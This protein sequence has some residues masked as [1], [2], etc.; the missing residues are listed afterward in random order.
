MTPTP[1]RTNKP[2]PSPSKTNKP[3]PTPTR[4]NKPTPTPTRTNKPTPTPTRTN[5]PTPSPSKTNKPTP[6]PTRTPTPTMFS[7]YQSLWKGVSFN[8]LAGA[9]D[10]QDWWILPNSITPEPPFKYSQENQTLYI[11]KDVKPAL[12]G[13]LCD[14]YGIGHP[15]GRTALSGGHLRF[16]GFENLKYISLGQCPVSAVELGNLPNFYEN[17]D[18]N[19]GTFICYDNSVI[20]NITTNSSF[21]CSK[22]H[23][24]ECANV[25]S[26]VELPNFSTVDKI[27]YASFTGTSVAFQE[28]SE[29]FK[30][31]SN[32]DLQLGAVFDTV[33]DLTPFTDL[34]SLKFYYDIK[35]IY[36][37]QWIDVEPW[38]G[39]LVTKRRPN[40]I[41]PKTERFLVSKQANS[42]LRRLEF[43][44]FFEYFDVVIDGEAGTTPFKGLSSVN[45]EVLGDVS[46]LNLIGAGLQ[47][48]DFSEETGFSSCLSG[49][50]YCSISKT[51]VPLP[52]LAFFDYNSNFNGILTLNTGVLNLDDR[53]N[54]TQQQQQ[55]LVESLTD[56]KTINTF[57]KKRVIGLE[58]SF[59]LML[60]NKGW[61]TEWIKWD[62]SSDYS[63]PTSLPPFNTTQFNASLYK[64]TTT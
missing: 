41:T 24:F 53:T 49:V 39:K 4:T 60:R 56:R 5:K 59:D 46:V 28:I 45:G 12:R 19:S 8:P 38:P 17:P 15:A 6:T 26:L 1:T 16:D 33:L 43:F 20:K 48:A 10:L 63:L 7:N 40:V 44:G 50:Q 30:K 2:T 34:V 37:N 64:N 47:L 55:T 42:N 11:H 51:I 21:S 3:T 52:S 57:G 61:L 23:R 35:Y 14:A 58:Q 36:T 27:K 29:K 13:F 32:L 62:W 54:L 9:Y 25:P 22:I 31:A 18:G